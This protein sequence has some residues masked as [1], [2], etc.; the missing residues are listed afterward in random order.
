MLINISSSWITLFSN[1]RVLVQIENEHIIFFFKIANK[2]YRFLRTTLF[3]MTY[4][5]NAGFTPGLLEWI[6][7]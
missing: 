6:K 3:F 4:Y 7:S 5:I 2:V 1:V